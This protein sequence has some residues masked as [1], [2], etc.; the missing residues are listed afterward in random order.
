MV[1]GLVAWGFANTIGPRWALVAYL[2]FL[3]LSMALGITDLDD[4]RIVDRLNL[5]GTAIL[6]I[7]LGAAS[8]VDSTPSELGRGLL[9]ALAYFVGGNVVFLLA[10]GR[11][12]GYGD[13]KLAAQLG[14]FTAF[15]SWGTLGWAVL[16]TALL[17]GLASIVV[18]AVGGIKG[19]RAR[20]TGAD[21]ASLREVMR[22]ELPYGPAMIIGAWG[23][24]VL[25][26]LG[27]FPLPS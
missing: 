19:A 15:L 10:R 16:I 23:A 6:A 13:V 20:R 4:F 2:G 3:V 7:A 26:G 21:E 12:F 24:I 8:L 14:L 27:A 18:L 1:G 11:G 25:A 9:G 22:T 5:R 17:G